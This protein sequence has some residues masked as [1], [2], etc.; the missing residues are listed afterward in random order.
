MRFSS[1]D[2]DR[3]AKRPQ[4]AAAT[5]GRSDHGPGEYKYSALGDYTYFLDEVNAIFCTW[6]DLKL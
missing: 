4:A 2:M 6:L 1:R 3:S 5:S